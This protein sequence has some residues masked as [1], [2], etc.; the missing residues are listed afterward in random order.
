MYKRQTYRL[1]YLEGSAQQ[2]MENV[3]TN[4]SDV[5][6]LFFTSDSRN[7][8]IKECNRR[9]IFFQHLKYNYLHIYVFHTHP[10]ANSAGVTFNEIRQYPFVSY[11]A[12]NPSSFRFTSSPR[13]W[14]QSQQVIFV[15]DRAMAYSLI[16]IGSAYITGSGYLSAEDKK[17]GLVAI[18][19]TDLGQIEIGWISN[20][21]RVLSELAMEYIDILKSITV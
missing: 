8:I 4:E 5:G 20:P 6:V 1:G 2:V 17:R 19:I 13:Q 7:T 18:P 3:A 15:S 9:N 10:L 11:D 12:C 21:A 16:S 14:S